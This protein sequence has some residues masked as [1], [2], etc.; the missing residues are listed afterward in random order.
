MTRNARIVWLA[1]AAVL[2]PMA[3]M[4][5]GAE[6]PFRPY[7]VETDDLAIRE[8]VPVRHIFGAKFTADLSVG[9]VKALRRQ[10]LDVQA[11]QL[12]E[13]TKLAKCDQWPSCKNG[14]GGGTDATR[15]VFPDDQTP[16]GTEVAYNDPTVLTTSGGTLVW[17]AVLDTGVHR[18]HLDLTNRAQ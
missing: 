14:G 17:V 12:F 10:G 18:E 2:C 13:P 5:Q 4:A 3:V 1:A 15:T 9:Q 6:P 8:S 11:V 16:W 7:I